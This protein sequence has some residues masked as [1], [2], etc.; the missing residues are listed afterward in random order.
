MRANEPNFWIV[1][2]AYF[3]VAASAAYASGAAP[4]RA[5]RTF[6]TIIAIALVAFG[7]AKQV[8]IQGELTNW[9][10]IQARAYHLYDHRQ[11]AQYPFLL[12]VLAA[13]LFVTMRFW[14]SRRH[15]R[16]PVAVAA[17]GFLL[18]TIFLLVRA[19]S[20]HAIDPFMYKSWLGLRSGWWIELSFLL[21]IGGAAV[22]AIERSH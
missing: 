13:G 19:P 7:L 8:R 1:A 15:W 17:L 3:A 6:W 5:E 21:V 2:V 4:N 16:R 20:L 12:I 22:S 9:I 14:N 11:L 10:R 18:L